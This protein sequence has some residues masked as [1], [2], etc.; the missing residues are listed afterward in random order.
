MS[1][2][3]DM[4]L[5][6]LSF[7][8]GFDQGLGLQESEADQM[9][10]AELDLS[11]SSELTNQFSPENSQSHHHDGCEQ[12]H[13]SFPFNLLILILFLIMRKLSHQKQN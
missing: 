2:T 12:S 1:P 9:L 7:Q 4:T 6:D 5:L 10:N 13:R 3:D 11:L 8:S